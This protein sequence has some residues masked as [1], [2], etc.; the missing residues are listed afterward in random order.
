MGRSGGSSASSLSVKA[1]LWSVIAIKV[2]WAFSAAAMTSATVPLPS[3]AFVWTWIPPTRS[4][5]SSHFAEIG[6][7]TS[8]PSNRI[9]AVT[10]NTV[11]R[12]TA[13]IRCDR[14]RGTRKE[15]CPSSFGYGAADITLPPRAKAIAKGPDKILITQSEPVKRHSGKG[16]KRYIATFRFEDD[17]L[18][19][20]HYTWI[21]KG[22]S[23]LH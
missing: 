22:R 19:L 15:I 17:G 7:L 6:S 12:V 13:K 21:Q 10:R 20:R 18:V 1:T 4:P 11:A 9:A 14:S 16:M 23:G 3:D 5:A 2:R 8:R